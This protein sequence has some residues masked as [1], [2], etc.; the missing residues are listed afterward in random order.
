MDKGNSLKISIKNVVEHKL[1]GTYRLA[2]IELKNPDA[3]YLVKN[4]GDFAFAIN[5]ST[6]QIIVSTDL[7]LFDQEKYRGKYSQI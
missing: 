4:S 1:L 3:L 2:V 6:D 7:K 5:K